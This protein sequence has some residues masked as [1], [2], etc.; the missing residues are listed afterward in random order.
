MIPKIIHFC[1]LSDDPLPASI[2]R[3]IDSWKRY[4]PDYKIKKWSTHNF[5]IHSIPLVE[6]AFN[7]RKYAF[8]ADYI[9]CYALYTEGGIYLDSDVLIHKSL[10]PLLEG[11]RYV[12]GMEFHP[13]ARNLYKKQVDKNG[14]RRAEVSEVM[15]IGLQ[16]AVMASEPKHP[17]MKDCLDFYKN[18]TLEIILCN[19]LLAPIV[20]AQ[21]A[22][23]YGY[24]YIG[25]KQVLDE[26]IV[27]YPTSII[28]QSNKEL[29]GRY[30]SHLCKGSWVVKNEK[31]K[32]IFF[33]DN[34][35]LYKRYIW[36]KDKLGLIK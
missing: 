27:I 5:D 13:V 22:E 3:C 4:M 12:T 25:Q 19:H 16:A 31:Q 30:C 17:L 15:G 23:K 32:M 10:S 26:G 24:R 18:K 29:R 6:Q 21:C 35:G 8:A 11:Q 36:L 20:Q 14:H 1:W 7:A 2:Q 28:G 33:L 9:R 34:I